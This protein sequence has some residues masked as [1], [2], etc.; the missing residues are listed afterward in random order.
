MC[1]PVCLMVDPADKDENHS[2]RP[3]LLNLSCVSAV[4]VKGSD[5]ALRTDYRRFAI[6]TLLWT[7]MMTS[8]H[9]GHTF[10]LIDHRGVTRSCCVCSARGPNV[11]R[12]GSKCGCR[13]CRFCWVRSGCRVESN[14][15]WESVP[16]C[17]TQAGWMSDALFTPVINTQSG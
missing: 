12:L 8:N 10:C 4:S 6:V 14:F 1:N 3:L 2:Q 13:C 16:V 5:A 7:L 9:P 17:S 11:S 15:S